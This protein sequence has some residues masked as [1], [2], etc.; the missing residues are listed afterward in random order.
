ME[1]YMMTIKKKGV[2]SPNCQMILPVTTLEHL[3]QLRIHPGISTQM[4]EAE[5]YLRAVLTRGLPLMAWQP[6]GIL[7]LLRLETKGRS[8][9][10]YDGKAGEQRIT[11]AGFEEEPVGG[12]VGW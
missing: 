6:G 5:E 8:Q 10:V 12:S 1:E 3:R 4:V 11:E 9:R 2:I 7:F